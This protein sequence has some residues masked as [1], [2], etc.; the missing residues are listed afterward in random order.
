MPKKRSPDSKPVG[1]PQRILIERLDEMG[2]TMKAASLKWANKNHSYLRQFIF[3]GVPQHLDEDARAALAHHTGLTEEQLGRKPRA[4][5]EEEPA[6]VV[7]IERP[8]TDPAPLITAG[9]PNHQ[10]GGVLLP[11]YAA[12]QGGQ[13]HL[14]V[15]F[16][17]VDYKS[18]P[19]EVMRAKDA[20][21]ILVVG[22]SMVPAYWPG[23]IVWVTP[24]KP[25][26][27]DK[28]YVLYHGKPA[29][30]AECM[31]KRL[32]GFSDRT[33]KLRQWNPLKDFTEDGKDWPVRHQIHSKTNA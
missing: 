11:V 21:G 2:V 19:E 28:D 8:R 14:I 3:E 5:N 27:R 17:P 13:G 9:G 16:D 4:I 7:E 6:K 25:L 20:H 15:T 1:E 24:Y 31:I 23:D 10:A 30:E 12:T 29:G 22:D 26:Q 32:V 33:L 18:A